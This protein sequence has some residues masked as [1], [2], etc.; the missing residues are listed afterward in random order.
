MYQYWLKDYL[1]RQWAALSG[2]TASYVTSAYRILESLGAVSELSTTVAADLKAFLE[3]E[4]DEIPRS[5][6]QAL[7]LSG[8][9]EFQQAV[10]RSTQTITEG[11]CLGLAPP[12]DAIEGQARSPSGG[13]ATKGKGFVETVMQQLFSDEGKSFASAVCSRMVR[14]LA[15]SLQGCGQLPSS[16]SS[17]GSSLVPA[18][19]AQL[20]NCARGEQQKP[21]LA[22]LVELLA[23]EKGKELVTVAVRSFAVSGM[24]TYLDKLGEANMYH[25]L[26]SAV[27]RH[28]EAVKD[29]SA[30]VVTT[31][32]KEVICS[33]GE[34]SRTSQRAA[35]T[36]DCA[37]ASSSSA[38]SS[39][40]PRAAGIPMSTF[41]ESESE[42]QPVGREP[43]KSTAAEVA[44]FLAQPT[45]RKLILDVTAVTTS[46][47]MEAFLLVLLSKLLGSSSSSSS[48]PALTLEEV[49]TSTSR[50]C[51]TGTTSAASV[52]AVCSKST[53]MCVSSSGAHWGNGLLTWGSS[54]ALASRALATASVCL[55]VMLHHMT[56]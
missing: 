5:V 52:S 54:K 36:P 3:S 6:R 37:Y 27:S 9:P 38:S 31:T 48:S 43:V 2:S 23:T 4:S 49:S 12:D 16:T 32:V 17:P 34:G 45:I 53:A 50:D 56:M 7:K 24:G 28:Q 40:S 39:S 30:H 15:A 22:V 51:S 11:V 44:E 29:V 46:R 20:R 10:L 41:S 18:G 35:S 47:G 26:L 33:W 14:T 42:I 1:N 55:A 19:K 13:R 21:W 25:D 8:S